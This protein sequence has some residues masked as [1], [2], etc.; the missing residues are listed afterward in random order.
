VRG[1]AELAER[2]GD[3]GGPE[4]V[5]LDGR[6]ERGVEAD[7]GG[8]VDHDVAGRQYG[9]VVVA[10]AEPVGAHVAGDDLHPALDHLVEPSLP[11]ELVAES[12]E[13]VVLEDLTGGPLLDGAHAARAD[14]QHELAARHGPQQPL[15]QC[16]AQETG[17]AGDGNPFPVQVSGD[18]GSL[19]TIW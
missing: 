4:Q 7:R 6:I 17:G 15:D 14:E 5:D 13:A 18:H 11:P 16:G 10:Q 8:R 2:A 9:P 1:H 3:A 19:F 12:V